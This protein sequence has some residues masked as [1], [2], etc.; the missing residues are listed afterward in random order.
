M[1]EDGVA[2]EHGKMMVNHLE[3]DRL[4]EEGTEQ[5]RCEQP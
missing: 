3:E 1:N 4:H 5:G 2:K